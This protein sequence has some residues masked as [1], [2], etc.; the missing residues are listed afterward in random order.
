MSLRSGKFATQLARHKPIL[1]SVDEAANIAI[2]DRMAGLKV[3]MAFALKWDHR[4][5]ETLLPR[6]FRTKDPAVGFWCFP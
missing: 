1:A 6:F 4:L 3:F 5:P 2:S